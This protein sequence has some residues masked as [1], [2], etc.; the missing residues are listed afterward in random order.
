[1]V[2]DKPIGE[3]Y[4]AKVVVKE[5][6]VTVWDIDTVLGFGPIGFLII[7]GLQPEK[8]YTIDLTHHCTGSTSTPAPFVQTSSPSTV[9]MFAKG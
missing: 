6:A 4:S 2:W 7:P 8:S 5:D 1:M 9:K 3:G